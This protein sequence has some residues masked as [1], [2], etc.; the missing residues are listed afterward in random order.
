MKHDATAEA[1][2][3][4]ACR[5]RDDAAFG[6][7]IDLYQARIYGFVKRMVHDAEDAQDLTQEVF[8]R[9]YQGLDRFD[10]RASL[11]T[12]L[13]RIATNL[14]IDR[15]RRQTNALEIVPPTEGEE[16]DTTPDH[17]WDPEAAM[18]S[19]EF[20]DVVEAALAQM[21]EKLRVV[22]LLHDREDMAY[23]EIAATMSLPVGT[24]KSRL[25]LAR[26]SL[27]KTLK[28]YMGTQGVQS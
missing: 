21:S 14:C 22:L 12:W 4:S 11:R 13:F 23:E 27:Q 25:F 1:A 7:L 16:W 19:S 2:L 5:R 10:G 28:Q 20:N 17:R 15:S 3:V 26:E 24:V 8:I 6:R 9:A 18:L